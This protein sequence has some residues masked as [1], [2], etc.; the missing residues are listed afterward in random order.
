[1]KIVHVCLCGSFNDGWSYQ[2]NCL[3]NYHKQYGHDVAVITTPFVNDKESTG[4]KF[5]KTGEYY[6]QN[7]IKIIRKPLKLRLLQRFSLYKGVYQ[8]IVNENPDI[9]FIHGCQFL[10][11]RYIVKY[12]KKKPSVRIYID[13]H[14]DFGNSARNWISKNILHKIIWRYYANMVEPY[15]TKF[16]G[17]LPA[18]VDFL[19]DM[20]KLP[21]EKV[22]LL[23]LGA[24]DEK[25]EQAKDEGLRVSLREKYGIKEEDFLIITGGKID[26]NKPQV[27]LL[28]EA[29]RKINSG[30]VKLLVFGSVSPKYK[31]RLSALLCDIVQYIGWIDSKETYKYFNAAELVV[32]PGLHSVFWEQ[33]IGLEKP[34]VFRYMEGFTHVDLGGNCKFL[35]EDSVDEIEKVL[36]EIVNNKETYEHMKNVATAKG[37]EVFSYKKIAEQSI[38]IG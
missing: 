24:E 9:F 35:Y 7:G 32:F 25:V 4:Y 26:S 22:E 16:Y 23:V 6:D 5:Y 1:M 2:E 36:N 19:I 33:V 20:Y 37:M 8:S 34:C 21:K 30:K 38:S 29:V 17:V 14:E 11:I 28:M 31:E 15:T 12:A 3:S 10:D 18:R 27:L 13:G